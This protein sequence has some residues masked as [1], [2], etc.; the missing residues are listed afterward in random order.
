MVLDDRRMRAYANGMNAVGLPA[1]IVYAAAAFTLAGGA[2][3]Y[4]GIWFLPRLAVLLQHPNAAADGYRI[5]KMAICIGSVLAFTASLIALTL[6]WKRR[7]KRR[8]RPRR[9][10]LACVLVVIA[11]AGFAGQGHVLIYD[12]AFAV[13]LAYTVAFTFVRYGVLDHAGHSSSADAANSSAS[14]A[15]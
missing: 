10:V 6:P 5:F 4:S 8:G 14:S 15:E 9:I 3:F 12:L 1:R 13:W 2:G 7:K 11:S